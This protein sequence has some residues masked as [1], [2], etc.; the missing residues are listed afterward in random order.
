MCQK[1]LNLYGGAGF[2]C[3]RSGEE[4]DIA[5]VVCGEKYVIDN[6]KK[7]EYECKRYDRI[8]INVISLTQFFCL[9]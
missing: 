6:I 7:K 5:G 4:A 3:F 8:V 9:T 1:A 2:G